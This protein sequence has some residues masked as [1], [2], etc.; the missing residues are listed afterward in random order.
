MGKPSDGVMLNLKSRWPTVYGRFAV[1]YRKQTGAWRVYIQMPMWLSS[2]IYEL[3][4]KPSPTGWSLQ[5]RA[6]NVIPWDSEIFLR[7]EHG[8]L[9][10]VKQM[11][12][13]RR[14]SLFDVTES[15]MSL[16][17]VATQAVQPEMVRFFLDSGLG[18]VFNDNKLPDPF[19]P[20]IPWGSWANDKEI[21]EITEMVQPHLQNPDSVDIYRIFKGLELWPYDKCAKY[22][23][24]F[25]PKYFD[26]LLQDRLEAF[27]MGSFVMRS[28]G[29]YEKLL[30]S[31]GSISKLD[32]ALS[33]SEKLSVL[34]SV[35]IMMGRR[36]PD[37]VLPHLWMMFPSRIWCS[38]WEDI[39]I[40]AIKATNF[41]HRHPIEHI[42]PWNIDPVPAWTGT[43]FI[44]LIAGT[45]CFLANINQSFHWEVAIQKT[46]RHWARLLSRSG[47]NLL[48]YG[49][50]EQDIIRRN[51]HGV[52]GYFDADAIRNTRMKGRKK[53]F[54][55]CE[56]LRKNYRNSW[57][58]D[59][60]YT[61]L[62]P[63]QWRPIRIID[64]HISL[65]P[66]EWQ[67]EWVFEVET[68]AREFWKL[69][70]PDEFTSKMPGG[71]VE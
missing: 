28:P 69:V 5:S 61:Y 59:C 33:T 48:E 9:S 31:D 68:Y 8:D 17:G 4:T 50:E 60:K 44:S 64:L 51:K 36:Y 55:D 14:A 7:I 45:I 49:R 19:R 27:R 18:T 62:E 22:K 47:V 37:V 34:H 30:T 58:T 32:A 2:S 10:G 38:T 26:T 70:E 21:I 6:Y 15:G 16:L 1:R 39:V 11:L 46:V 3:E 57:R 35:A 12:Q 53:L 54:P 41:R 42:V 52:R 23:D 13:T 71:W 25:M 43:P 65:D 67:L 24:R 40:R 20:L 66:D 29:Q 56:L 63:S